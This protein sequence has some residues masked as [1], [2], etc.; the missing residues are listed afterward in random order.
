MDADRAAHI[1]LQ[2]AIIILAAKT[3]GVLCTRYLKQPSVLGELV[4]GMVIGPHALGGLSIFGLRPLFIVPAAAH[5]VVGVEIF[6]LGIL[7]S[8]VL[9][10]HAGLETDVQKFLRYSVAGL[11]TGLSGAVLSF[12]LGD[13]ATVW[14]GYAPGGY[15][16]PPA[17]FM[18]TI[19]V[20]T[21]VG[22]TAR[23]LSDKRKIDTPEGATI[24]SGAVIDD[25]IGLVLLAMV[26][27]VAAQKGDGPAR[28]D[29]LGL[30]W[31][32]AKA[33]IFWV[34]AM[35]LGIIFYRRIGR[36]LRFFGANTAIC[37]A[38]LGFAFL[39]AAAAELAGLALIIGAYTM[40]VCLSQVDRAHKLQER[41]APVYDF[42]VPVF[43]CIMGMAVD[44][45]HIRSAIVAGTI[46]ALACIAGKILGCGLAAYPL[47][48]N[49]LGAARIGFGMAPR[50]EVALIVA[51]AALAAGALAPD[52]FGAVVIMT[53]ITTLVAPL[54]LAKLSTDATGLRRAEKAPR[55][56]K[57][58][59]TVEFPIEQVAR[60][61]ADRMAAAFTD[62][63]FFVHHRADIET[64][65]MRKQDI[66]VFLQ[67][68]GVRLHFSAGPESLQYVRFIV[69]EEMVALREVFRAA[70]RFDESGQLKNLFLDQPTD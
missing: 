2:V 49:T 40:G 54:A 26:M 61:V 27:T 25:V 35:A 33:I 68:D 63:S 46:F 39:L 70:V 12:A 66:T 8:A 34:S 3:F 37:T 6:T 44:F 52:A 59:F 13:A 7:A 15:F 1:V 30:V 32:A 51:G 38:T 64:W 53:F 14:M 67:L 65:E 62:E 18:G 5:H 50:Q 47:G 16:S 55:R 4:A 10:F 29:W 45:A 11:V 36:L 69:I 17:L 22:V 58:E 31:I 60:L 41:L 23:V 42:L 43:F 48:F 21:S 9:L 28:I 24:L 56:P 20:A 57:V 19:A